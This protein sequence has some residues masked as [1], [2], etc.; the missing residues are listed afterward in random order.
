MKNFGQFMEDGITTGVAGVV[1]T[2]DDN[3]TVPVSVKM[4]QKKRKFPLMRRKIL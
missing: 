4:Q 2:G 3:T 1:G